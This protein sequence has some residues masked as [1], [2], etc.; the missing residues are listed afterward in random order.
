M[1]GGLDVFGYFKR[2]EMVVSM[3]SPAGSKEAQEEGHFALI[4]GKLV[5]VDPFVAQD[6]RQQRENKKC[7]EWA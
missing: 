1:P 4:G 3:V 7:R 5:W 2:H 6:I